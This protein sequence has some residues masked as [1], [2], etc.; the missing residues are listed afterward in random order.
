MVMDSPKNHSI[1][2]TPQSNIILDN[3]NPSVRA[4][5]L[6]IVGLSGLNKWVRPFINP[7]NNIAAII[8]KAHIPTYFVFINT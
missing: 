3:T 1:R 8:A 5:H 7:N 6:T 4:I 2:S